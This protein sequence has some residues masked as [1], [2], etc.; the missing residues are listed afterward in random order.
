M[1]SEFDFMNQRIHPAELPPGVLY[2]GVPGS[3]KTV[4]ML[5]HTRDLCQ[6]GIPLFG[7]DHKNELPAFFSSFLP[8]DIPIYVIDPFHMDGYRIDWSAMLRTETSVDAFIKRM[9]PEIKGDSQPHFRNSAV[10]QVKFAARL[11]NFYSLGK[12]HL[13]DLIRLAKNRRLLLHLNKLTPDMEQIPKDRED[14]TSTKDVQ[15]TVETSLSLFEI[16]AALELHATKYID[17]YILT[18]LGVGV[19][20]MAWSDEFKSVLGAIGSFL[21]DSVTNRL[22]SRQADEDQMTIFWLD[23]LTSLQRLEALENIAKRGRSSA[24]IPLVGCQTYEG[25]RSLYSPDI[26]EQTLGILPYKIFFRQTVPSAKWAAD[27]L[28]MPRV[29]E[30]IN[31]NNAQAPW[32]FSVKDGHHVV[33]PEELRRIPT[34]NLRRKDS[35]KGFLD[36][37]DRVGPFDISVL[38]K[39]QYNKA[40]RRKDPVPDSYQ[41]LPRFTAD[42]MI[43]LHFPN[44]LSHI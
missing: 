20:V 13:A 37:P 7:I 39:I 4:T 32:Q 43:R 19:M 24:V 42:D 21:I 41:I 40:L 28:G 31:T 29:L 15:S 18:D 26:A 16:Y 1:I 8:A 17:P 33:T 9:I 11:L 5:S 22:L 30:A 10:L 12:W 36:F 6:M 14:H 2:L 44:C 35:V 3:G 23:E 38:K 34:P 27:Y 25:V